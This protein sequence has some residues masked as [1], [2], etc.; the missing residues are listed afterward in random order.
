MVRRDVPPQ[1]AARAGQS[2]KVPPKPAA[3]AGQSSKVPPKPA[4]SAGQSSKDLAR[5][6]SAGHERGKDASRTSAKRSPEP[7]VSDH[8]KSRRV[9]AP[10]AMM[11]RGGR[12]STAAGQVQRGF[13]CSPTLRCFAMIYLR[14][15]L[16]VRGETE[17]REQRRGRDRAQDDNDA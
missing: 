16:Q 4:T 13:C 1:P 9:D 6:A 12:N 14:I 11:T 10:Q 3:S 15:A 2:S 8:G 17:R 7:L 5:P